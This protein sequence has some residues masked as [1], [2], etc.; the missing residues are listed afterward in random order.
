MGTTKAVLLGA[1]ANLGLGALVSKA[2]TGSWKPGALYGLLTSPMAMSVSST[3]DNAIK[4]ERIETGDLITGVA[5]GGILAYY[6]LCMAAVTTMPPMGLRAAKAAKPVGRAVQGRLQGNQGNQGNPV[7]SR[8]SWPM[9]GHIAPALLRMGSIPQ[10]KGIPAAS[11]GAGTAMYR[12]SEQ[13]SEYI[14]AGWRAEATKWP[15][16]EILI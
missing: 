5:S 4:K 7:N 8:P 15:R 6:Y 2:A 11:P 9:A 13:P 16:Q 12:P 1:A 3:V 14:K 10:P